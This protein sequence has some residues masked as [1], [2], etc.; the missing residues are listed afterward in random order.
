MSYALSVRSVASLRASDDDRERVSDR[1]RQATAE[2]R[3]TPDELE[4][5]LTWLYRSRTYGELDRLVAD[6]P[7][8][9]RP[10]AV[11]RRSFPRW[12]MGTAAGTALLA[13]LAVLAGASHHAVGPRGGRGIGYP[14]GLDAVHHLFIAGAAALTVLTLLIV[15]VTVAWVLLRAHRLFGA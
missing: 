13:L 14:G 3:L 5:R 11:A 9:A 12:L 7:A 15:C 2:G 6:L 8:P 4:E 1:L 10:T